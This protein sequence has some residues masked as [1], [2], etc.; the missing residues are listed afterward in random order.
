M[1]PAR[2][3]LLINR[4]DPEHE[5]AFSSLM[6]RCFQV[7]AGH[8]YLDDFPVWSERYKPAS[9]QVFKVGA[10][11]Q[12]KLIAAAGAQIAD[13]KAN[14]FP[15]KVALIGAV[16]TDGQYRGRGI[17]TQLVSLATE[18]AQGQGAA[19]AVLWGSEHEL[20]RK[21]GF[22]PCGRQ[23]RV[24]ISAMKSSKS[25]GPIIHTGW[26]PALFTKIKQ[27]SDG[28]RITDEDR[29]WYEAHPNVKWYWTGP[30]NDPKAYV[31]I[32]RGI[33]LPNFIHEWGGE[34]SALVELLAQLAQKYPNAQ[35]L[36]SPETFSKV[37]LQYDPS[38]VEYLCLASVLDPLATFRSFVPV[39]KAK[40]FGAHF[41]RRRFKASY[42]GSLWQGIRWRARRSR[43]LTFLLR[44][45][46]S[47]SADSRKT[48]VQFLSAPA[49][50]LG[51]RRGLDFP[52]RVILPASRDLGASR[53][54][55][56]P[57]RS[58]C[59][60][61]RVSKPDKGAMPPRVPALQT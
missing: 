31:A 55:R 26:N 17:A 28:L 48:V 61:C 27:R 30:E 58:A 56:V 7:P 50:V 15:M 40:D 33:D 60:D 3:N 39:S 10:Y 8:H 43:R 9:R 34:L 16:A 35:I 22:Y 14:A 20:Y 32:G 6:D 52:L 2:S 51:A 38:A 18:W 42:R 44:S 37:S 21:I 49:L 29:G 57:L 59:E 53:P 46:G 23:V 5:D 1:V 12:G 4:I 19:V 36:G 13:L 54:E 25:K 47:W 24:A 11:D 45:E 41:G